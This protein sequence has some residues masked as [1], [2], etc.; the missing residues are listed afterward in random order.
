MSMRGLN[1]RKDDKLSKLDKLSAENES[2]EKDT[3][4]VKLKALRD[5]FK[6]GPHHRMERFT[7]MFGSTLTIML[8][9]VV[10]GFFAHQAKVGNLEENTPIITPE[11][12]YS[13]SGE[14]GKVE[15]ALSNKDQTDVVFLF[16][17]RNI[18][19]M[20]INTQNYELFVTNNKRKGLDYS[21]EV[22]FGL[23]GSTGYGFIRFEN[24]TPIPQDILNV[25]VRANEKLTTG[26]SS[27]PD[28][29]DG[30]FATH[31]Q[32]RI[33]V[34]PGANGI[35]VVEDIDSFDVTD[36][37]HLYRVLIAHDIDEGIH[38]EID[39]KLEQMQNL[40]AKEREYIERIKTA[41][42]VAPEKP[43]FIDGDKFDENGIYVSKNDLQGTHE[44]TYQGVTIEQGYLHQV[45]KDVSEFDTYMAKKRE[46]LEIRDDTRNEI[47]D[48]IQTV[49]TK[50]G[51][52]INLETIRAGSSPA[53]QVAMKESIESLQTVWRDYLR[54][55]TTLQRDLVNELLILDANVQSQDVNFSSITGTDY[56]T[57]Y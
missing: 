55:K 29:E 51:A 18:D 28:E 10:M 30:S 49:T 37:I 47:V 31:D 54:E 39:A 8:I 21:P 6:L 9:F 38:E 50:D 41:G 46:E 19:N 7:I 15:K 34:N 57:F 33:I 36:P 20:S 24:D 5:K 23:F 12:T 32:A 3:F 17:M 22:T 16:K 14:K 25:T 44:I 35:E 56:V 42:Y 27:T 52:E 4:G 48:R 1:N 40:L 43:W 13:L 45:M 11:F 2:A 26:Q 53:A